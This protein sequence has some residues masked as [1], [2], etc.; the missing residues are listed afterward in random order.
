VVEQFGVDSPDSL[1]IWSMWG[2]YRTAW[3]CCWRTSRQ[4]GD[5]GQRQ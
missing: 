1:K 4:P 5:K 3:N 2:I